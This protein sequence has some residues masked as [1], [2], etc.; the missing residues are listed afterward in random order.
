MQ[1]CRPPAPSPAPPRKTHVGLLVWPCRPC[2]QRPPPRRWGVAWVAFVWPRMLAPPLRWRGACGLAWVVDVSNFWVSS[3]PFCCA[4][5][6]RVGGQCV[7]QGCGCTHL[8]EVTSS[9]CC[10]LRYEKILCC[11]ALLANGAFVPALMRF[12]ARHWLSS[13]RS[14]Q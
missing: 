12:S 7:L 4:L 2:P 13:G 8:L 9:L 1:A 6:T 10:W 11:P 3:P 14:L 5:Q